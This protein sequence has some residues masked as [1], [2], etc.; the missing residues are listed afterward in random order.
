M[1]DVRYCKWAVYER[2]KAKLANLP[3][4][5]YEKRLKELIRRLKI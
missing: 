3:P 4:S 5:E 1:A 2:E